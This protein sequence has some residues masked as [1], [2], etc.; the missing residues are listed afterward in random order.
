[1]IVS[2]HQPVY[3]P[4]LGYFHKIARSDIHIFFDDVE[5]S[6]NN[7]FNR[8]K[9]KT[10]QGTAWLTIPVV[11]KNHNLIN[12]TRIDVDANWQKKHWQTIK[13]NYSR[14]P[15]FEKY[16]RFFNK[17]YEQSWQYLSDFNM[18]MNKMIA[19]QFGIKT[20]FFVSS[21]L[22]VVGQSNEKLVNLCQAVKAD[23]YFSGRGAVDKGVNPKAYLDS[24]LFVKNN[25]QVQ[26]QDFNHPVYPQLWGGFIPNLSA[27]DFLFNLGGEK[28][29]ELLVKNI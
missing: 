8:N 29:K 27:I 4:W 15:F 2:I 14:A 26:V 11:Y 10:P 19:E 13:L 3:I 24:E 21:Q 22:Q 1:M 6:K 25:I 7:L 16:E 9:I 12:Q 5:Y 23:I 17:I 18:A 28:F 20:K